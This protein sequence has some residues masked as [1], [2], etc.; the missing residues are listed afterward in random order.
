MQQLTS[1]ITRTPTA[2]RLRKPS[3]LE[4]LDKLSTQLPAAA[5]KTSAGAT[6]PPLAGAM[7]TT[8]HEPVEKL[9]QSVYT[10]LGKA[11]SMLAL[12]RGEIFI[13]TLRGQ[14]VFLPNWLPASVYGLKVKQQAG[15]WHLSHEEV[16]AAMTTLSRVAR[17][18]WALLLDF[19]DGLDSTMQDMLSHYYPKALMSEL[20]LYM[21]KSLVDL[22]NAFP[23][24]QHVEIDNLMTLGQVVDCLL[25]ISNARNREA[26]RARVRPTRTT[27]HA[28]P[29]VIDRDTDQSSSKGDQ[30]PKLV[31]QPSFACRS[32]ATRPGE[33]Q[34]VPLPPRLMTR[35]STLAGDGAGA[36][37]ALMTAL[38]GAEP[39]AAAR[40]STDRRSMD[41]QTPLRASGRLP[42]RA[43]QQP[44]VAVLTA[45]QSSELPRPA[46]PTQV[47]AFAAAASATLA[48]GEAQDAAQDE[49]DA[50]KAT[51]TAHSTDDQ[52][53][54]K[55]LLASTFR[56]QGL[57]SCK[58]DASTMP[59]LTGMFS[60]QQ[61]MLTRCQT[62]NHAS[63][64]LADPIVFP[65]TEEGY[66]CQ[67]RGLSCS[68][69]GRAASRDV[70]MVFS[71]TLCWP[72]A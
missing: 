22:A 69:C 46:A 9:F 10:S 61:A 44:A 71:G 56:G 72:P 37:C 11:Q 18:L 13:G 7:P 8:T 31:M 4:R 25:T 55:P 62:I 32:L 48:L 65:A 58:P 14:Y 60:V 2:N 21:H 5:T 28:L 17:L 24:Q 34:L 23:N 15:R 43:P 49:E 19:E 20:A 26:H 6:A 27:S 41:R 51:S 64:A 12:T 67:V 1:L 45:P 52:E 66:V 68:G 3:V 39:A 57:L 42:P 47:S 30:V 40:C 29:A 53:N 35:A 63:M 38:A 59:A 36:G 33:V 50:G 70:P 54:S 16:E